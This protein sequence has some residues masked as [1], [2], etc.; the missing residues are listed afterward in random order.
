M[1]DEEKIILMAREIADEL[2]KETKADKCHTIVYNILK[3][4]KINHE[5]LREIPPE[6]RE[7]IKEK[8]KEL[9]VE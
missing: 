5:S 2:C 6:D 4:G 1:S 7:R 3:T 8:L 9:G